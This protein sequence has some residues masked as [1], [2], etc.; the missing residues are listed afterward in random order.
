M[1]DW[2]SSRDVSFHVVETPLS[3]LHD[4]VRPSVCILA[5][6]WKGGIQH[7]YSRAMD[8][9]LDDRGYDG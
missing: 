3:G 5:M 7:A 4:D 6:G 2:R 9:R 8:L 1:A